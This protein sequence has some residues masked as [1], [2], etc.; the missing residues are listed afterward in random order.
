M[1]APGMWAGVLRWLLAVMPA[2]VAVGEELVTVAYVMDRESYQEIASG[3]LMT[4]WKRRD[5]FAEKKSP[6]EKAPKAVALAKPPGETRFLQEGN[7]MWSLTGHLREENVLKN[8][9]SWAVWNESTLRLVVHGSV[10]E[11]GL[12]TGQLRDLGQPMRIVTTVRLLKVPCRELGVVVWS[13]EEVEKRGGEE[14]SSM[15]IMSLPGQKASKTVPSGGEEV[16]L[17]TEVSVSRDDRLVDV[18][19][20]FF[21]PVAHPG[22]VRKVELTTNVTVRAG[23]ELCIEVGGADDANKSHV[24]GVLAVP[25]FADGTAVMK[26]REGEDENAEKSVAGIRK[27]R[28]MRLLQ[29]DGLILSRFQLPPPFGGGIGGEDIHPLEPRVKP[30]AEL[31]WDQT[32]TVQDMAS[33]LQKNGVLVPEGG[34]AVLRQDSSTLWAKLDAVNTD[35]LEDLVDQ[36]SAPSPR[37]LRVTA[38]VIEWDGEFES[39]KIPAGARRLARVGSMVRPGRKGV[40]RHEWPGGEGNR[41]ISFVFE[42]Q[43]GADD[44]VIEMPVELE[45]TGARPVRLV[46]ELLLTNGRP[47]LVPVRGTGGTMIGVVFEVR[48]IDAA[49]RDWRQAERGAGE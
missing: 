41:G 8:Q 16:G 49:G 26:W 2:G 1:S 29:D 39:G 22:G 17:T 42:P 27:G 47:L 35:R 30:P 28:R 43:I 37:L 18:R 10:W 45:M 5:P 32:E 34:W 40:M 6:A 4:G 14:L 46:T 7:P 3:E 24:V 36:I 19:F 38:S 9:G 23:R 25:E 12:V 11:H 13:V 33:V 48:M 20:E 31:G 44:S 15:A 21:A